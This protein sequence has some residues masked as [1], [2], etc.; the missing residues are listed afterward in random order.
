VAVR[1][2][3]NADLPQ[4]V[5][6]WNEHWAAFGPDPSVSMAQ[7][8]QAI[9]ART[10]FQ[11]ESLLVSESDAVDGWCLFFHPTDSTADGSVACI[12]LSAAASTGDGDE[13]LEAAEQRMK[14]AGVEV[15]RVG[16][17]RDDRFGLAGLSPIGQGIGIP[18]HDF[19]T[20]SILSERGYTSQQSVQRM[21]ATV[22]GYRPPVSR[23]AMQLR[24]I[25]QVDMVDYLHPDERSAAAMSHLDVEMHRLID[26]N[27]NV[28]ARVNLWF[29]DAEAEVMNPAMAIVDLS[30]LGSDQQISPAESYLL[31]TSIQSLLSRGIAIVETV[32]DSDNGTLLDQMRSLQFTAGESGAL[33]SKAVE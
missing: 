11:P 28:L 12:C 19:R 29:S 30:T 23:D 22:G 14:E 7:F 26:R 17:I 20:A 4:L 33:W 8:E 25:T 16:A 2:F 24:R 15:I 21:T 18:T 5:R 13:L 1:S 3:C 10:Y 9:L 6:L 32:V 27:E 31:G